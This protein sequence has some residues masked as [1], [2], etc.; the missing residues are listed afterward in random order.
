MEIEYNDCSLFFIALSLQHCM[1]VYY[2]TR[3]Q[4]CVA[5]MAGMICGQWPYAI[6]E[7]WNLHIFRVAARPLMGTEWIATSVYCSHLAHGRGS[8]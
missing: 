4:I 3:L 6:T 2:E 8:D 5:Q 7:E 1:Y